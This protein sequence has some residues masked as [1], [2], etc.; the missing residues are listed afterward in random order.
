[1]IISYSKM[2]AHLKQLLVFLDAFCRWEVTH[3]LAFPGPILL[4][5]LYKSMTIVVL[6]AG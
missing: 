2:A 1:M 3:I 6:A 5:L 4:F